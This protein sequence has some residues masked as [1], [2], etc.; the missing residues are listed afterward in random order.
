MRKIL[1]V[2]VLLMSGC[3]L[4]QD[5]ASFIQPKAKQF[6]EERGHT[7]VSYQGYNMW[8]IGR[9]YW[10][11]TE[12][13]GITYESCLL[14]WGNEIHEYSLRAIDAVRGR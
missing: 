10:Y 8:T 9:C 14:K 1:V 7:V 5:D 4:M 6:F 2:C 3:G 12:K 11:V 13:N